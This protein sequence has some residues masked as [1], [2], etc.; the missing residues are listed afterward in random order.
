MMRSLLVLLLVACGSADAAN[1]FVRQ[2]ASGNGSDWANAYGALPTS[3]S[4]GDTY[5][6][7][8]GSYAGYMFDDDGTSTITIK[9]CTASDHG[10]DGGYQA[11]YCDGQATFGSLQFTRP[12]YVIDGAK[13]NESNWKDHAAYGIRTPEVR[14]SRL[15]G[16]HIGSDCSADN[17]TFRYLHVGNTGASYASYTGARGFYVGGF[18]GGNM[19][20]QNWTISRVLMQNTG[21]LQCAGGEGLTVEYTYFYSIWSKEA[22]RGQVHCKN[23]IVR[24]SIFEDACHYPPEGNA[25]TGEIAAWDG[26]AGSMDHWQVYGNVFYKTG[27]QTYLNT[28]AVVWVG[29]T[30]GPGPPT[31]NSV[32]YNNTI[33]G[34]KNG[35]SAAIKFVGSGNVCRNNLWYDT[36]ANSGCT[37][38]SASNNVKASTNPFVNYTGGNFHL[39]G[40][41]ADG[42][43][44][45]APYHVDMDGVT[46]GS[47]G[48]WDLGAYEF[49]GTAPPT[50]RPKPP[51]DVSATQ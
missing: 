16:G 2:G 8:D 50:T 20:C 26:A 48:T 27:N 12:H 11:G 17:L 44:L 5:Y 51:T 18:G 47:D 42:T 21:E 32:A 3:L 22:I 39:S 36:H 40:A 30:V 45:A 34:I 1:R 4:R 49:G 46:R 13:R 35:Y 33:V 9:K 14:A 19:A 29:D 24:Y 15:D 6:I 23:A 10:T 25:C 7:A 31:S 28:D 37:A 41:T 38:S 43:T